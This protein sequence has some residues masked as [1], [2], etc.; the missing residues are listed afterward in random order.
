MIQKI[1]SVLKRRKA[2]LFFLFLLLSGLAWFISNLSHRYQSNTTFDLEF[3]NP[4]DSMMLS[5]ASQKQVEV[6]LDAVGFQFLAFGFRKNKA[7]IDLTKIKKVGAYYEVSA[8]SLKNQIENQLSS[9]VQVLQINADNLVFEFYSV[10]SKKVPVRPELGLKFAQSYLL[11]G[12]I[13]VNPDSVVIKGPKN[14]IDTLKYVVTEAVEL[15]NLNS[16]FAITSK[17]VKPASLKRTEFSKSEVSLSGGVSRFS[18][19]ILK[20]P[21]TIINLPENIEAQTF[22]E[23]VDVLIKARLSDLKK[24]K[25]ADII[26][27]GDYATVSGTD[28]KSVVLFIVKKPPTV[29]AAELY[30]EKVDFILK[31]E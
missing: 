30:T 2:K 27:A 19:K 12:L 15:P 20:L 13:T 10:I 4:P 7:I 31:R 11:D 17:L 22:P 8:A 3:V 6:R 28:L 14:E 5:T 24:L 1:K 25:P 26:V 18:E 23:E 16:D 29:R 21:V 9:N